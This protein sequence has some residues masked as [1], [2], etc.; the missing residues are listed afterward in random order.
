MLTGRAFA[1]RGGWGGMRNAGTD[2]LG[3]Q[4]QRLAFLQSG[5]RKGGCPP[6]SNPTHWLPNTNKF[7]IRLGAPMP[8]TSGDEKVGPKRLL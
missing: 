1:W 8:W 6:Q 2:F 3:W 5:G 7:C 4:A